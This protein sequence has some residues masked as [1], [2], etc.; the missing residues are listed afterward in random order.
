MCA[1]AGA[2]WRGVFGPG[3][4]GSDGGDVARIM[5]RLAHLLSD[6]W[7]RSGGGRRDRRDHFDAAIRPK[8]GDVCRAL[9]DR[10]R[11]NSRTL[12]GT[13]RLDKGWHDR[14]LLRA[15]PGFFQGLPSVFGIGDCPRRRSSRLDPPG[16]SRP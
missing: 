13:T 14:G 1:T 3:W 4:L 11:Y 5:P 6:D 7:I 10:N 8:P 12:A 15:A 2:R 16:V 9:S